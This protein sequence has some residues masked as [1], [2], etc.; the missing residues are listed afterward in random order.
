MSYQIPQH[1]D[2]NKIFIV[3]RSE[4][5]GRLDA[6]YNKPTYSEIWHKLF[7]LSTPLTTL[8]NNS[9]N[10]F[11]GITPKSGGDAYVLADGI[12]FVRSGDFSDVNVIDL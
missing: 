8:K 7:S 5:E 1:I 12:P 2:K 3:N 9:E 6:H 11:S 10:I 4:I